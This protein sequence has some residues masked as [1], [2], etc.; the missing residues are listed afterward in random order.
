MTLEAGVLKEGSYVLFVTSLSSSRTELA[1][2]RKL[3]LVDDNSA[4]S[5]M[6]KG[7]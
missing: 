1:G 2:G 7:R 5:S 4:P 6:I 3:D